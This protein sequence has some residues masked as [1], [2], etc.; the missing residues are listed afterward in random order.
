MKTSLPARYYDDR[1]AGIR[2]RDQVFA[3]HWSCVGHV[4]QWT[5]IGH[6]R[7][8][9]IGLV[10]TLITRS[11]DGWHGVQAVC[12]HRAGPLEAC[13]GGGRRFLRCRYHGWSYELD[14]RLL[15]APEMSGVADFDPANLAL[16]RLEVVEAMGL[17]FVRLAPGPATLEACIVGIES[18]LA[19]SGH[20]L[21]EM[22]FH[23]HVSYDI[24]CNW[25]IYVDNYLEGY[26]VPGIHPGL[27]A[28]LDY[29][30]YRTEVANWHSLQ[31]SPLESTP[32]VY[33][34]GEAL[35][36]FLYP[37]TMLNIL[38]GRLQTNRVLPLPN[39]RCRVEFD[40]FYAPDTD[41]ERRRRDL[42]FSDEVQREDIAICEMVQRH[43]DSGAYLPGPLHPVR[44]TGVIHFQTLLRADHDGTT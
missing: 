25:K 27:D 8:V 9:Q 33:G 21:A 39:N 35:Y 24:D 29:R 42:A 13:T 30:S 17:L 16:P 7:A 15:H 36:Y 37:S 23:A 40:F 20:R 6:S 18:R 2:D 19:R 1:A 11:E 14:G 34:S 4:S 43:L 32:D 41:E 5:S 28:I 12:R 44:E 10:P 22:Q 31:W 38:P 26:H 3:R